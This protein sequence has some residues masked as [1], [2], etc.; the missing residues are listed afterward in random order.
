M[1]DRTWRRFATALCFTVFG[2]G[3]L[4]LGC[5]LH[6]VLVLLIPNKTRRQAV[7]RK[8]IHL[9]FKC[10]VAFMRGAGVLTY[11]VSGAQRL[12]R[13][14][15]LVLA[16]HPTLIDV[17][18]LMSL[19][20]NADCIVKAGLLRN[21]FTR[22]PVSSAGFVINDTGEH[23]VE[24]CINTVRAGNNLIICP[25]GTRTPPRCPVHLQRGASHV[26]LRGNIDITP[27]RIRASE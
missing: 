23:L 19:I 11:E 17:V 13:R 8:A 2:I 16:N 9:S 20:E 5:L 12:R 24:Q 7:V 4:V 10:F 3:S 21:P 27:V 22:G 25:E 6:P 14:G 15:L 26:A 18:L 1:L